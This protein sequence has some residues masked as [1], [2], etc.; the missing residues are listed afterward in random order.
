MT[1]ILDLR[2]IC[3]ED[4]LASYLGLGTNSI[5]GLWKK[6]ANS[7]VLLREHELETLAQSVAEMAD[8]V[9]PTAKDDGWKEELA[10]LYRISPRIIQPLID[11]HNS[12]WRQKTGRTKSEYMDQ[13]S[14]YWGI[15][16]M[17][18]R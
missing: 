1:K 6:L 9:K 15:W 18:C 16:G 17:R 3:G 5:G 2:D 12:V 7:P 14:G 8:Y 10:R 11:Y 13:V 4:N